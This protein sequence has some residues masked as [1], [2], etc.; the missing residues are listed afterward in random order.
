MKICAAIKALVVWSCCVLMGELCLASASWAITAE[1]VAQQRAQKAAM[2]LVDIRRSSQYAAGHI[3]GAINIPLG[4]CKEIQLPPLG[5]VVVYGD[6]LDPGPAAT[7][8]AILNEKTGIQAETMDG[9]FSRW[10]ALGYP[11]TQPYGL[12]REPFIYVTY[13][14]LS[15]MAQNNPNLV[16]MDLRQTAEAADA[17]GAMDVGAVA[18]PEEGGLSDLGEA[19]PGVRVVGAPF[20]GGAARGAMSTGDAAAMTDDGH[21]DVYVLIDNGDARSEQTARR[22]RAA[23]VRRMVILVGGESSLV[24]KGKPGIQVWRD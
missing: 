1:M 23:G 8:A 4:Q 6:G 22:L 18:E 9:G 17:R 24:R 16:L 3:P 14:Q 10:E 15:T 7:A 21:T 11:T 19:F 12:T 5:D 2:T 20:N 13:E